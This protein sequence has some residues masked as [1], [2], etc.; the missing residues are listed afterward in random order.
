GDITMGRARASRRRAGVALRASSSRWN[1]LRSSVWHPNVS[2]AARAGLVFHPL[3]PRLLMSADPH[4]VDL[5]VIDASHQDHDVL[6]RMVEETTTVQDNP[7]VRQQLQ[8]VDRTDPQHVLAT[9]DPDEISNVTILGGPGADRITIDADSFA[10]R[11]APGMTVVG[12]GGN[13]TLAV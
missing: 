6:V 3:E 7:I 10:G 11:Q 8:V 13:D 9:L 2:P 4:V 1:W 12:G 5:A